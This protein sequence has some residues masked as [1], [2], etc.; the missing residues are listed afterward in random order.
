MC[1]WEITSLQRRRSQGRL[2]ISTG[3]GGLPPSWC[4]S[5]SGGANHR[6]D[7]WRSP[8]RG[9]RNVLSWHHH[10][11]RGEFTE[12]ITF[13]E[14][15]VALEGDLRSERFGTAL[16]QSANS[17]AWLADVLSEIGRFD[18]AIGHAE[19]AMRIAEEAD[20]PYTLSSTSV[21]P[22]S[23]AGISRARRGFSSGASTSPACGKPGLRTSRQLS[24]PPTRSLVGLTRHSGWSRTLSKSSTQTLPPEGDREQ[25]R[26][27]LTTAMARY[28]EM[29]MAY[30]L[31]QAAVETLQF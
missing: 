25:A 7:P 19:A 12:A 4:C 9:G 18:E 27:H 13:F 10:L 6:A 11:A 26:E 24:G 5:A 1:V 21:S 8:G 28:R 20:H 3:S 29:G 16:I 15:N 14:R 22:I 30:W 23:V 17:G 2:A 31:E